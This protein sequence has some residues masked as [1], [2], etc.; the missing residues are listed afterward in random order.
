MPKTS[1]LKSVKQCTNLRQAMKQIKTKEWEVEFRTDNQK[2]FYDSILDKDI[3][4]CSGP[5]GTGKTFIGVYFALKALSE[6]NSKYDGIII[7]KPLV[8]AAGEKL[9]YLP[10]NVEE[11][12][13]PFM[14]SFHY[15]MEQLV[16]KSVSD[17]L[18]KEQTVRVMPLAYMRGLTLD[19]KIVLLDEAQNATVDQIKMFLTRMGIHSKIII[20]G[21]IEQTDKK[22]ENGLHDSIH[23]FSSLKEVGMCAFHKADIVRH[24]L[25]GKILDM[26]ISFNKVPIKANGVEASN[27]VAL[28]PH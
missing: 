3:T 8:E 9:G 19:K 5:A 12:T 10:G 22:G 16:G 6:K 27:G 14:M 15:N 2:K 20:M 24:P 4:F 1:T 17:I 26:Y 7:T 11:K 21:D 18:L 23:R 13:D 25:I 28:L